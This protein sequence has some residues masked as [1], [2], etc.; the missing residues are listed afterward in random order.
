M[1]T[2]SAAVSA[3]LVL[4]ASGLLPTVALVGLRPVIVPLV[5]LTGAVIAAVSATC[6]VA[7]GGTFIGWFAG[8]SIVGGLGI[9][10]GWLHRPTRRPWGRHGGDIGRPA[11]RTVLIGGAGA[12]LVL[13]AC[14]W[15]LRALATP[16][17]GFDARALW[18]M[19]AGWFLQPHAQVLIKLRVPDVVLTQSAY[20]PLV[21]AATAV[22]WRV[23]GDDSAR[24]GVVVVAVLNTCVL[25]TAVWAMVEA[26]W[27][28]AVRLM[29]ERGRATSAPLIVGVVVAALL[30]F[31]GFGITEPFMTNGYA[32]PIWSLAA[33][34]AVAFGLQLD[35]SHASQAV[36]LLL[37]LVA[38]MSKDEGF[39]TAALLIGLIALRG[40]V[41]L[42]RT[43]R[44]RCW[45]PVAIGL[46]ELVAISLWP[47]LMRAIHARGV[48]SPV[49][50]ARAFAGR[51]RAS[52]D[53]MVPYL[54]V[55]VL[56]AP[57]AV[58]GGVVLAGVRRRSGLANDL[59]A[60]AGLACGLLAIEGAFVTGTGA[61]GPWLLSTV[62]RVTEFA[63]LA[64][65]WIVG[66]W[67]V[68][69]SGAPAASRRRRPHRTSSLISHDESDLGADPVAAAV[70]S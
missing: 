10:V 40:V 33:V 11:L 21:S 59:W 66:M 8:L 58:V 19:R 44:R 42:W 49:S 54:H 26:G 61:I 48:S 29:P 41:A 34:G 43:Q 46:G 18:L 53:G 56:A 38:G 60:W 20:P 39:V 27:R 55:I 68:V 47:V 31:V 52:Y 25:I 14:A 67:A 13:G 28:A 15:C 32:D 6:F 63:A 2:T 30:V 12:L 70:T 4:A 64:G 3:I 35:R 16:T 23:T 24:L 22:A 65:W 17:V 62:H 50:P 1:S 57:L 9:L 45:R 69:A 36:A 37:L 51:A 7:L 5:P